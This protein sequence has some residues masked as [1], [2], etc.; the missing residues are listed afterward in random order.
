[1]IKIFIIESF[2]STFSLSLAYDKQLWQQIPEKFRRCIK[3]PH[4]QMQRSHVLNSVCVC[5][6]GRLLYPCMWTSFPLVLYDRDLV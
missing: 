4:G 2:Y 6:W 5:V 3:D 1:M